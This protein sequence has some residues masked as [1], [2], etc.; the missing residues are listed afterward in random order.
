MSNY[1]DAT[2]ERV[3]VIVEKIEHKSIDDDLKA[4]LTKVLLSSNFALN[5]AHLLIELLSKGS[6]KRALSQQDYENRLKLLSQDNLRNYA[7]AIR[8]FR[9]Y[10]ILRILFRDIAGLNTTGDTLLELSNFADAMILQGLDYCHN[11]QVNIYGQPCGRNNQSIMLHVIAMGKL[12]GRELNF[13]SD[14]DLIFTYS[15]DGFTNGSEPV[16]NQVF[17]NR[18]VQNFL[19][20]FTQVL[21]E[22]I[23]YRVDLRLRPHGDSGPLAM[24]FTA[25]ENYYQEQGRDWERYAMVKARVIGNKQNAREISKIIHPF[26]YRRYVD[27]S[28]IE[29]LRSM[30][31]MIA[32]E[33]KLKKLIYDIKRGSGGIREIEFITQAFQLIKGG[34]LPSLQEPNLLQALNQLKSNKILSTKTVQSLYQAYMFLR[35]LENRLQMLNDRQTHELPKEKDIKEQIAFSLG[36]DSWSDVS[37]VLKLHQTKVVFLFNEI[38]NQEDSYEDGKRL[39]SQQLLNLFHGHVEK[40]MAENL[41]ES[42]GFDNP[43]NCYQMIYDFKHSPRVRRITQATRMRLEKL[44]VILLDCLKRSNNT[45]QLLLRVIK[46]LDAI[47]NRSP[48]LA[49]LTENPKALQHLLYLF[50]RSQWVAQQV[51]SHPFLLESLL[52]EEYD[53]DGFTQEN[54]SAELD[55]RLNHS[56]D[57]EQHLEILRQFKLRYFL[58]IA[59]AEL[60]EKIKAITISNHLT[61]LAEVLIIKV[62]ELSACILSEKFPEIASIKH[63]FTV[64]AYGKLGSC[65]LNYNSDLDLVFLHDVSPDKEYLM[66]RLTQKIIH[67]LNIRA[68]SGVLYKVDTRLRPSGA[69][70]LLISHIESFSDYQQNQAWTWEHQALIRARFIYGRELLKKQ[71]SQIRQ[72]V[73]TVKRDEN[74]LANDIVNMRKKMMQHQKSDN[75]KSISGGLIDLEFLIQYLVLKNAN[76]FPSLIE[77]QEGFA[78]IQR[79]H[80]HSCLSSNQK[81]IMSKSFTIYHSMLHLETLSTIQNKDLSHNVEQIGRLFNEILQKN[82]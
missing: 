67:N 64:I 36:Y 42:L 62:V 12:G 58:L 8:K 72:K 81:S 70:G 29:S 47:V 19:K 13:S 75:L 60:D 21:P 11:Q 40:N 54:L 5:N 45:E 7:N 26:V 53:F 2:K 46:L 57:S 59:A 30:K 71:F 10:Y 32:R 18:V 69:A 1:L 14:I 49:L 63:C 77:V 20:L 28:V 78:L 22:G 51:T 33:V 65:E 48:Y 15:E 34:R 31:A 24:G 79:L 76:R 23:V 9:K 4:Q 6:H 50:S 55:E 66:T 17:F 43:Q 73:L 38:L 16:P 25:L 74:K 37:D 82:D 3:K 27:F 56:L 68:S 61:L 41:L 35:L 80:E 52:E 39:L 44:M